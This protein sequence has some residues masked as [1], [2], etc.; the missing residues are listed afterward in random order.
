MKKKNLFYALPIATTIALS[1]CKKPTP[2]P[3]TSEPVTTTTA[4]ETTTEPPIVETPVVTNVAPVDRAAKL[5]FAQMLP[6][7][8]ETLMLFQNGQSIIDSLKASKLWQSLA[9]ENPEAE[10]FL[11]SSGESLSAGDILSKEFFL[12]T[13]KGTAKQTGNL[14]I[15]SERSAYHSMKML[16]ST[17]LS[18]IGGDDE[19]GMKKM[20]ASRKMMKDLLSDPKFGAT[21][22]EKAEMPPIYFG[23]K[24]TS[25]N[26]E[27]VKSGF[28]MV[29]TGLA[30]QMPFVEEYEFE[31]GGH[32]F[33]GTRISGEALVKLAEGDGYEQLK[34]QFGD[35]T[36]TD[37]LKVA[38]NKNIIIGSGSVNGYELI[39]IGSR[40]EDF[41]FAATP[42][43]SFAASKSLAFVDPYLEKKQIALLYASQSVLEQ[44]QKSGG[45]SVFCDGLSDG[46]AGNGKID[47]REIETLLKIVSESEKD[48][49]SMDV[50]SDFG[51]I[52]M[53]DQGFRVETFGGSSLPGLNIAKNNQLGALAKGDGIAMFANWTSNPAY[54]NAVRAYLEATVQAAYS[55]AKSVAEL[56]IE[57]PS[58]TS[59]KQG[60]TMFDQTFR[61]D[62]VKIWAAL[63]TQMAEGIG[64]ETAVILDLNGEMPP[65]PGVP[66]EL[67][68][69]GVFP[70]ISAISPVADRAKLAD[71]WKTINASGE[72]LMKSVSEM[73]GSEQAMPK[74]MSSNNNDLTTWFFAA[75]LFTD[76][77][78]PSV[79]VSDKWFVISSSKKHAG[80]LVKAADAS[81]TGVKGA[82]FTMDFGAMTKFGEKWLNAVEK[83]KSA[84][85]AGNEFAESQFISTKEMMSNGLKAFSEFDK[86]NIH[87]RKEAGVSRSTLHFKT[88]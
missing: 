64:N 56:E 46:L 51:A 26:A 25:E 16:A 18:D 28:A 38:K 59:F 45:I 78:T 67:V 36:T 70:R 4:G 87:V 42:A 9:D 76:D 65:I 48:V 79:S 55:V 49:L 69:D 84:V 31:V 6:A 32:S 40:P 30:G 47:T 23:C 12:A 8:T 19:D 83:N 27:L 71:S 68:N 74:P 53:L 7:D 14:S 57:D 39:L 37:M 22:L 1:S 3:P 24:T 77:F 52:A 2:A 66:Q 20:E 41:Q 33:K 44:A 75:P 86:L 61:T 62:A 5:G 73:M 29:A 60:F 50:P 81:N 13:G 15:Y 63:S 72:N 34:T 54:D 82:F 10:A 85:F 11:D 43:E 17:F 80:Y 35:K 88:K 21:W 58:M